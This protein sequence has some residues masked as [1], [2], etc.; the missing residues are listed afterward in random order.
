MHEVNL[1]HLLLVC[2]VQVRTIVEPQG[3]TLV[4]QRVFL[5]LLVLNTAREH[6][7][8]NQLE[9]APEGKAEKRSMNANGRYR[10][11]L[12]GFFDGIVH[13]ISQDHALAQGHMGDPVVEDVALE[14]MQHVEEIGDFG[15][16]IVSGDFPFCRT[17]IPNAFAA[18][19]RTIPARGSN[20][21]ERGLHER[22]H[23]F[24]QHA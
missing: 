14:V 4:P 16:G 23:F 22:S 6:Q 1:H 21:P 20:G 2:D 15:H 9:G 19:D 11:I 3:Q 7:I 24:Q 13:G 10:K 17:G 8:E 5:F 18:E 12:Q